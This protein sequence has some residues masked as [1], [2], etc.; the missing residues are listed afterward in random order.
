MT[1][2]QKL[3]SFIAGLVVFMAATFF[4][5]SHG[6]LET[7]FR[8]YAQATGRYEA[9]DWAQALANYYFQNESWVGVDGVMR[10]MLHSGQYGDVQVV[11]LYDT[12]GNLIDTVADR[13]GSKVPRFRKR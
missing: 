2:R 7:L 3:L 1:V 10:F 5:L 12:N 6:Y 13:R 4:V 9:T 8:Q 11:A